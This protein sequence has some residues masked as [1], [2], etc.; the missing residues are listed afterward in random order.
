MRTG[1]R[2]TCN[3]TNPQ[4]VIERVN[5]LRVAVDQPELLTFYD[6]KGRLIRE[7]EAPGV[8]DIVDTNIPDDEDGLE[9]LSPST[10][11]NDC[12]P[13]DLQDIP[14]AIAETIEQPKGS[15]R[16]PEAPEDDFLVQDPNNQVKPDLQQPPE[17]ILAK[18]FRSDSASTLSTCPHAKPTTTY[19][20]SQQHKSY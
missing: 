11:N 20:N 16:E 1:K 17:P 8:P 3:S 14:H 19:P 12:G 7:T 2:I 4:E 6:R 9:D 13:D 10:I 18:A 5:Q 15:V